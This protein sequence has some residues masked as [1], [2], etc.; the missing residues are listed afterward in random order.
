VA[1][2]A[3]GGRVVAAAAGLL[4]FAFSYLLLLHAWSTAL[5][6]IARGAVA[7]CG[8]GGLVVAVPGAE[9][10]AVSVTVA[11][12]LAGVVQPAEPLGNSSYLCPPGA[13]AL[14]TVE[15]PLG[16]PEAAAAYSCPTG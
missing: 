9:G 6:E 5:E 15:A 10:Q 12:R 2:R 1:A 4:L 11:C 7:M 8:P 13:E 3:A 14:V 16:W